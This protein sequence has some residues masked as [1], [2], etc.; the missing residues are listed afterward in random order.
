MVFF[1]GY[2]ATDS[3]KGSGIT[4]KQNNIFSHRMAFFWGRIT[5]NKLAKTVKPTV[6]CRG[7][8]KKLGGQSKFAGR[9]GR[10]HKKQ[11]WKKISSGQII[12]FQADKISCK[13][14]NTHH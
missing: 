14:A 12:R 3:K 1:C 10:F 2:F 4:K 9:I 6:N 5:T 7:C 11:I 8:K 13:Q